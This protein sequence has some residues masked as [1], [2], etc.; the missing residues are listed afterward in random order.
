MIVLDPAPVPYLKP[1]PA[2]RAANQPF[3]D[4]LRDHEFVVPRCDN[5]GDYNWVPYPACRS[6]LSESQTWTPVSGNATLYTY[7]VCHRGP[8]A[9]GAEV[10]YAIALAE[11]A[12]QPR[13][14]LVLANLV[15]CSLED[16]H[17]GMPLQ[18][19]FQDI[20]GE[21]LTMYRWAPRQRL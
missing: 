4:A 15:D 12:E 21:D 7:T 2:V 9:F 8:G 11:L 6:C 1:L 5:C 10:P 13:P 3:F 18:I 16:V 20:P 14:C 17:V 19:A